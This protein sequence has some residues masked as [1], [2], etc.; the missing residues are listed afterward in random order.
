MGV[1]PIDPKVLNKIVDDA[2]DALDDLYRE[3]AT[4]HH[5]DVGRISKNTTTRACDALQ[6]LQVFEQMNPGTLTTAPRLGILK[7]IVEKISSKLD[8]PEAQTALGTMQVELMGG[9]NRLQ[10]VFP[11]KNPQRILRKDSDPLNRQ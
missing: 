4:S 8:S 11:E 9:L 7:D 6:R 10:L 1:A 5:E 2:T 3:L